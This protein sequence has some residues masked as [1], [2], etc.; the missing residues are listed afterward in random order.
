VANAVADDAEVLELL[1]TP[2]EMRDFGDGIVQMNASMD[3]A[4][5]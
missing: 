4:N 5:A 1:G 2:V 3:S